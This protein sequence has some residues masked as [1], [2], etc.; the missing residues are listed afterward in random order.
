MLTEARYERVIKDWLGIGDP[1]KPT[2]VTRA[3]DAL[4]EADADLGKAVALLKKV[5]DTRDFAADEIDRMQKERT[6]IRAALE[7][8]PK[9]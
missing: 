3:R 9:R 5:E 2:K 7:R 6:R 1:V 8:M 4:V